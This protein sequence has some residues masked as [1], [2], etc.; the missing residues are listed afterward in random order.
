MSVCT[1]SHI[2]QGL[3]HFCISAIFGRN[4]HPLGEVEAECLDK[5]PCRRNYGLQVSTVLHHLDSTQLAP[6]SDEM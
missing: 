4:F 1:T 6:K 5:A 2:P 3:C